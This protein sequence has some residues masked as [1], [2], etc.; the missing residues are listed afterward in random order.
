MTDDADNLPLPPLPDDAVDMAA[1]E[2]AAQ[3]CAHIKAMY[4]DATEAVPWNSCKR[5]L[6]GL[7]R[8]DMKRIGR[9]AERGEMVQEI[10][11]MRNERV[12]ITK[13]REGLAND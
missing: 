6:S 5:S 2:I 8:N 12:K 13:M 9:A 4:P 1:R 11:G 10:A 7:I 3:V